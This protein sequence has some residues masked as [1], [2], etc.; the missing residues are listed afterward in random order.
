VTRGLRGLVIVALLALAGYGIFRISLHWGVV[1]IPAV[2]VKSADAHKAVSPSLDARIE[3][4]LSER[5]PAKAGDAKLVALTFDDGPYPVWTP[6]LLDVLAEQHVRA[7]FFL[8]GDD[9]EQYPLL[10]ERIAREGHEIGNHTLTHPAHFENLDAAGV[11]AELSGGAAVLERFVSDPAIRTMMR[12]PHGRYTEATVRAAQRAGYHVILWND[13]PGDWR[14]KIPAAQLAQ[15]LETH[16]SAP[17][18]ILLHSGRIATI[19]MLPEVVGRFRKAG[20]TFVTVGELMNR[21]PVSVIDHAEKTP[22]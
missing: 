1:P 13:D 22:V 12:P 17:D 2:V 18:I 11:A 9:A 15:H 6:L 7:T 4:F 16:A 8:V 20:F 14:T 5:A 19:Q 10:T 3:R 21:L